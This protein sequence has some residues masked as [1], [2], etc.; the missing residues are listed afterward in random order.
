MQQLVPYICGCDRSLEMLHRNPVD[1]RFLCQADAYALPYTD[2]SFDLVYCWELLHHVHDPVPVI[3]ELARV[4]SRYVLVFEPNSLNL[5]MALFGAS[6]PTERRLLRF[7]PWYLKQLLIRAG[8]HPVQ[9]L[10]AGCFTPNR[11]P[12]WLFSILKECPTTH[13]SIIF[14]ECFELF[15]EQS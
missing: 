1:K 14:H 12:E 11:T 4:S 15:S 3:K 5:P 6:V 7:T 2:A 8:I 13:L 10:T 9:T